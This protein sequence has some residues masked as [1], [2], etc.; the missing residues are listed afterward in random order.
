VII[1]AHQW[2]A[3]ELSFGWPFDSAQGLE[4]A[5][6]AAVRDRLISIRI[7]HVRDDSDYQ[8]EA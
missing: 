4:L 8:I 2:L 3:S 6:T 5:E 1:S 7:D